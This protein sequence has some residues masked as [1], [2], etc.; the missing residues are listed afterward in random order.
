MSADVQPRVPQI[1][2]NRG[3][4]D[5]P[6][7]RVRVI[8]DLAEGTMTQAEIGRKYGVTQSSVSEF[9]DRHHAEVESKRAHL[10]DEFHGMWIADKRARVAVLQQQV[11]GAELLMAMALELVREAARRGVKVGELLESAEDE[12]A[13]LSG[14]E[15]AKLETEQDKVANTALGNYLK[16][17]KGQREAMRNVAEELA[18]L[19]NRPTVQIQTERIEHVYVGIDMDDV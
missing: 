16:L 6:W 11:E 5:R 13:A 1:G 3:V 17:G 14:A 9:A 8:A 4:L 18:Q 10:A 12:G 19:P 2:G 7:N 15:L